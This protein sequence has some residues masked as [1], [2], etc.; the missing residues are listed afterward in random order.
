MTPFGVIFDADGVLF[1]SERQSL[2][3]LRRAIEQ[4]TNGT[5]AFSPDLVDFAC[6]RDDDSIIR[7]LNKNHGLSFDPVHFRRIKIECYR[8]VI[9]SDPIAVSPGAI[10]L[11]DNLAAASVPYAIATASIRAKLD[12]SLA[13]LGLAGRFPIITSADD[14]AAGKPDP[15][16]FFLSAK[17]LGLQPSR[18]IAFEDSVNGILAA[19]RAGMFSVGV[20]GTF[21][22]EQLSMARQVV[23]NLLQVTISRLRE[24]LD[25]PFEPFRMA[26]GE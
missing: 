25:G 18:I 23:E 17:R 16:V 4:V 20:L 7:Y 21:S 9:A 26:G 15:A 24:W 1:D 11:L 22:R 12:L 2:E 19:N 5:V 13:T 10:E 6:G 3:A 8:R 14:V